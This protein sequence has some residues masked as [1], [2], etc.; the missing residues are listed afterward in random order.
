MMQKN[1]AQIYEKTYSQGVTTDL[2][3]D[4]RLTELKQSNF[5]N[6]EKDYLHYIK[7]LTQLGLTPG[8]LIFDYGCSWGYGSYQ[9]ARAGFDVM[10]YEVAPSRRRYA[11]EK[12]A[13]C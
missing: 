13:G 9:L 8:A 3:S 11:K 4:D 1:N 6:S 5:A 2:P 7:V 12:L 10:S